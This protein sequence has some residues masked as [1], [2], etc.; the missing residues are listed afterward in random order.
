VGD[1]HRIL[2]PGTYA[3]WFYAPGYVPQRVTNVVVG[4]G[5]ATRLDVALQPV[6]TRFAAKVNF[7]PASAAVPAG[8]STDT[9]AVFGARSGGYTYGWETTLASGNLIERKA[10]RSQDLRYDTLCQ[11]QAGGSHTWEIAV[12]NGPYSVLVAAGDPSYSTGTY[13]VQAE[14][15]LLLSGT[16]SAADR[17]VEAQ[18]T[19]IVT[20]GR[21]TLSNGSGAVSNRLAFVEI[22]AVEPATLD[23]WRALWFGT[24]NN[25]GTAADTADPDSDGLPNFLEYAFGLNPTN[26]DQGWRLS[27][28]LTQTNSTDWLACS[29]FRNTNAADLT[30]SLQAAGTLPSSSWSNLVTWTSAAGWSA[31]ALVSEAGVGPGRVR[32]T[33]RDAQPISANATRYYRLLVVMRSTGVAAVQQVS[34]PAGRPGEATVWIR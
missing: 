3:L 30:F 24:T 18:G 27:P 26:S 8:Y 22:S 10:G 7:Q 29:F 1:Y 12:P 33:V 34:V 4:S 11:M 32:V 20:D 15:V 5:I 9:G 21:L 28:L 23:Q 25:S 31:P 19:V 17:W 6:S 2:L 14:N 16:P 13:R